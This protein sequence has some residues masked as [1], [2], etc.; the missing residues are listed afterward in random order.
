M[1]INKDL[2]RSRMITVRAPSHVD[3]TL[4]L[5]RA[6]SIGATTGVTLGGQS[7]GTVTT[8]GAL[9]ARVNDVVHKVNGHYLVQLPPA[10]A[11]LLTL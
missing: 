9:P 3:G 6:P 8:T 2:G 11:A 7:F 1:L 4:E 10:T 5:L